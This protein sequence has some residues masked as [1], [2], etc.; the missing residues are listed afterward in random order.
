MDTFLA[1][2]WPSTEPLFSSRIFT[3]GTLA[4]Y[5]VGLVIFI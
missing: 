4:E 1:V 2:A 5:S 3:Y